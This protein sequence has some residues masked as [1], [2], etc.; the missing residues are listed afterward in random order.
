MTLLL[1]EM[2]ICYLTILLAEYRLNMTSMNQ[3]CFY[4][5]VLVVWINSCWAH[6]SN[7]NSVQTPSYTVTVGISHFP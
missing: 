3:K 2:S 5:E 1:I 7:K 6:H 4:E